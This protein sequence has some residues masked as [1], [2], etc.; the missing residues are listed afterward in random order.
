ML[1]AGGF[2]LHPRRG[3][4]RGAAIGQQHSVYPLRRLWCLSRPFRADEIISALA[5]ASA[6]RAAGVWVWNLMSPRTGATGGHP[7]PE[8]A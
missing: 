8:G 1:G 2:C 7:P 6:P 3:S 4:V 5:V